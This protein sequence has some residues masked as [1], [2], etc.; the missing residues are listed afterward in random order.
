MNVRTLLAPLLCLALLVP[1]TAAVGPQSAMKAAKKLTLKAKTVAQDSS[2]M[3]LAALYQRLFQLQ[4]LRR[5]A[6]LKI[7]TTDLIID[8][9]AYQYKKMERFVDRELMEEIAVDP[10]HRRYP[11]MTESSK[12]KILQEVARCLRVQ[13]VKRLE[14]TKIERDMSDVEKMIERYLARP[15]VG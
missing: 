5:D 14:I 11:N 6:E 9:Y 8:D 4:D 15:R 3:A 12:L 10:D 7:E 2:D 13:F 1:A